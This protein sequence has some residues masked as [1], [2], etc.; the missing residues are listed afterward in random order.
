MRVGADDQSEAE[1]K[2]D[3][4]SEPRGGWCRW[5]VVWSGAGCMLSNGRSVVVFWMAKGE[6]NSPDLV[7][8]AMVVVTAQVIHTVGAAAACVQCAVCSADWGGLEK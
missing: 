3:V 8:W 6:S 5:R 4:C 1:L 2:H 7:G